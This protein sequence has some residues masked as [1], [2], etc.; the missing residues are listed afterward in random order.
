M[1]RLLGDLAKLAIEALNG[2]GRIDQPANLLRELE[3]R[4]QIRPIFPPGS[5]DPGILLS[6]GFFKCVQG[7]LGRRF[8]HRGIA[9]RR[10]GTNKEKGR[11]TQR[12]YLRRVNAPV[13][14][15]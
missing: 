5:S 8:I 9:D 4:A 7:A 3:I 11:T 12:K 2:I 13:F 10:R 14:I 1:T 6:P 15:V